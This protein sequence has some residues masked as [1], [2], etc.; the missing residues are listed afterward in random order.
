MCAFGGPSFGRICPDSKTNFQKKIMA[1]NVYFGA[2]IF[3]R[4]RP[5]QNFGFQKG[6][7]TKREEQQSTFWESEN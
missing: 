5:G 4:I 1:Q 2:A 3:G 6:I 7:V